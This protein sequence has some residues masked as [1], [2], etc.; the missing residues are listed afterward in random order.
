MPNSQISIRFLTNKIRYIEDV[1][2]SLQENWPNL[3]ITQTNGISDTLKD[4]RPNLII[5]D[6]ISVP[7]SLVHEIIALGQNI[8][9]IISET[10]D[11]YEGAY[12]A[13]TDI[14]I[15]FLKPKD[16]K[17]HSLVHILN[18]LIER[19]K[20]IE[21]LNTT[22]AQMNDMVVRDDL[23]GIFNKRYIDQFVESE[24]KK[25]RRYNTP[26][27]ALLVGVDS[28]K[29]INETY[30]YDI[31]N[32]ILIEFSYL[33]Q[34]AIREVDVVARYSGDEF[35]VLLPETD[36]KAAVKVAE[37]IQ[38]DI[39][40]TIFADG[41]PTHN[42]TASIGVAEFQHGYRTPEEW[43]T[44]LRKA[45][46]EAK[47]SGKDQI[48]TVE[49]AEAG[50][51][52]KI[53]EDAQLII[54]LQNKIHILTED[55][56]KTYFKGVVSLIEGNPFYKKYLVPHSERVAFYAEKLASKLKMQP[57]EISAIRR[58][59]LLHD[60]GKVAIDKRI[61]LKAQQL[62][63]SEFNLVKRHPVIGIQLIG[64]SLFWKNELTM[65]LHHHEWFNGSGYPDG[66]N[67]NHIPLGARILNIAEAWDTMTTD[68]PYRP[69]ITL[70][71]AIQEIK[72]NSGRQFDP[73]LASMFVSMI[74]S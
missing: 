44:A 34:N 18:N 12:R 42:P 17:S 30:G 27:T 9:I 52:L 61:L 68:Q 15:Y 16:I 70:D 5:V 43:T 11:D 20:L 26:V 25:A 2:N 49:D 6:S 37:R 45:L 39:H 4:P 3:L 66:L 59:G 47:H 69:A 60:V 40:N 21:K 57:E 22:N 48:K 19:Q 29:N 56:K 72:Q 46:I 74:E 64:H 10:G 51:V 31:G 23:T 53:S 13:A 14:P 28:L 71:K 35:Y 63:E 58:G 36:I 32:K 24:L 73:E 8:P 33:I 7:E 38:K 1:K 62:N 50:E 54:E 41:R 67:G 55:T 65:I